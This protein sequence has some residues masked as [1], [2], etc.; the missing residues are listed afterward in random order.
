MRGPDLRLWPRTTAAPI[1]VRVAASKLIT[2]AADGVAEMG[3]RL[4]ATLI[5]GAAPGGTAGAAS[6]VPPATAVACRPARSDST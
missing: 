6:C 3:G 4:V 1:T 5:A 2:S